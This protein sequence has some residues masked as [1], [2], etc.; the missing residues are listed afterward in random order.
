VIVDQFEYEIR[1]QRGRASPRES[2]FIVAE[3]DDFQEVSK[4]TPVDP[5]PRQERRY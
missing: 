5:G 2:I 3:N 4:Y 1:N